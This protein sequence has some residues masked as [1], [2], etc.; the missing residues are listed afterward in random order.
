MIEIA[1]RELVDDLRAEEGTLARTVHLTPNENVLSRLARSFLSSPIGFRYHLGT[2]S[3]RRA[4]DGVVDVHGLTLGYLKAV[5]ETEQ[6]AVGAAQGMFDAAIADLRPLSGVHAMITTL[7]AVTEPGDTV[8]SIDPA[9]GGHFATRH[10]LQRLGRVSEYLPWD[11]EALTIDVPRS[12]EAFL[13]T[14]PKAVL[15]DHGAPLYPLPV[16]ALRESCPSR[17]VL[18]YDGSHVL[19]LI[20]G[21][22]FQ[23][24]LADGCDILQ[25]NMHK[26][27]PG[28]Q[29]ALICAREGVIG[30]SV[31][32]NLS[33][34]F[35][36]SQHTHQSVAAYVTLLEME[37]YGQAYAVQMLSNSRS[38]AT[39]LKAAGFSLVESADTPSESHQ[40][41]VRTDGQDESIRW[42][43]RLLQ[44]GISV[45]ARRLYGHDVLR[46]AVQEVTRLGMIESDM[47]HIAEIFRT[48]LKGKTSASVLRSEC[49]S[50]GR[51][52]SRVLFS[53]DEHFEPVE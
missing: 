34:G 45:N 42:V 38:L 4:L 21:A 12:G 15:L 51:R 20:A 35:V 6:R 17:T 7:S 44:C 53:F 47:E 37:K 10:I 31:V 5:A 33:R 27:F 50:M 40:I 23:R 49:I 19:G 52:F 9:C 25:G 1:L 41:L 30:E 48:A 11:L 32:D 46:V 28:P 3:S 24:P 14:Q 8:Y 43:R 13:R 16:Q 18:I 29:K 36:S 22:K 2:I 26:S 39:S